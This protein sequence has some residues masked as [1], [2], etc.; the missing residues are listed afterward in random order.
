[1]EQT[2]FAERLRHHLQNSGLTWNAISDAAGGV[3]HA[4]IYRMSRGERKPGSRNVILCLAL[5]FGLSVNEADELLELA[6]HAI[7]SARRGHRP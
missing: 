7:V 3:D 4:Y 6:G 1:M 2:T 5:A